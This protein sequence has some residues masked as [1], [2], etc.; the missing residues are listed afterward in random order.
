MMTTGMYSSKTPEWATPQKFFDALNAEFH[1]TL[2]VC[3]TK[4]NAKCARYFTAEDDG[5]KAEWGNAQHP[6]V[7][8][9]NPPLRSWDRCV[10]QE[11]I[12]KRNGWGISCLPAPRPNRYGV[13]ARLLHQRRDTLYPGSFEVQ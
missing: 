12:R 3:A 2:D 8:W 11:G 7:C 4:E 10:G 1:F 6:D 9:M 5:L 13:V